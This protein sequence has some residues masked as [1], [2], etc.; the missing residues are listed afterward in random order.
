MT[1]LGILL[2]K[3]FAFNDFYILNISK[4]IYSRLSL[5]IDQ[6]IYLD[7]V[8][9]VMCTRVHICISLFLSLS[10]FLPLSLT[11]SL[12]IYISLSLSHSLYISIHLMSIYLSFYSKT[13]SIY[14][15]VPLSIYLYL[16]LS[17]TLSINLSNVH[18]SLTI[19][20]SHLF[21]LKTLSPLNPDDI[22]FFSDSVFTYIS[23]SLLSLYVYIPPAISS[24]ISD[25]ET[26]LRIQIHFILA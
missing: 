20:L 2:D 5:K 19:Y 16:S 10:L 1:H 26:F 9:F 8:K 24:N 13:L 17:F 7:M 21:C 14:L 23:P 3:K 22:D 11:L 4:N 18:L 12:S 6:E 25:H 15:S